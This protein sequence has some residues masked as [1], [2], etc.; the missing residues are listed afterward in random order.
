RHGEARAE[1]KASHQESE[2]YRAE[3]VA[4][5]ERIRREYPKYQRKDEVLFALADNLYEI[6][7]RAEAIARYEE[8]LESNP[9]SS[10]AGDTYLQLGNHYFDVANDLSRAR[11]YY[12][13]AL[14]SDL[15]KVHSYALYKLAWCDYNAGDFENALKKLQQVVAF[16]QTHGREMVD[17]R[18]EAL[19]DMTA[20]FVRLGR[21]A[22]ALDYLGRAVPEPSQQRKLI[23][24]LANQLADTGQY[25]SAIRAY[26]HLIAR[27]PANPDTPEYQRSIVR[28]YE[29][30]RDRAHVKAEMQ[31]L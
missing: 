10:F 7:R 18:N 1:P 17:L 3:A 21:F 5:Y 27:E 8:L 26:R 24:R 9:S 22:E 16:A 12:Q 11:R 13:K 29:E 28:C 30:L 19:G 25:D 23:A 6:G 31:R 15:A 14:G 2:S 4:L 20:V